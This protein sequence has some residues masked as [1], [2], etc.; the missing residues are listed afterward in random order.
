M[1]EEE[2]KTYFIPENYLG[3][4]RVLNGQFKTRNL[5]EAVIAFFLIAIPV[6]ALVKNASIA[7][8][9]SVPLC[10]GIFIAVF[11]YNGIDDEPFSTGLFSI[12][13]YLRSRKLYIYEKSEAALSKTPFES[14]LDEDRDSA[15]AKMYAKYK[16][17]RTKEFISYNSLVEGENYEREGT[18]LKGLRHQ[19]QKKSAL[20]ILTVYS[21]DFS[22]DY[23]FVYGEERT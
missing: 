12:F 9:I 11:V 4:G 2:V 19:T 14:M 3:D 7:A 15:I 5:I 20:E 17:G 23:T 21:A 1:Q 6:H 13:H 10:A 8:R 22:S 16:E 18:Y